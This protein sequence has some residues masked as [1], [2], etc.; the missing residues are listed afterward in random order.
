MLP[1]PQQ[2]VDFGFSGRP[3][4]VPATSVGPTPLCR[5]SG[6]ACSVHVSLC[7]SV[8]RSMRRPAAPGLS[9]ISRV[10]CDAVRCSRQCKFICLNDD[11][12]A[13]T[14]PE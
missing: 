6:T 2:H 1:Q 7:L 10:D 3:P 5:Q 13:A 11:F 4:Q 12:P 9:T 14:P 8:A